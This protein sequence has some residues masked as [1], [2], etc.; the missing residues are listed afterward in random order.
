M[1]AQ[2]F[3]EDTKDTKQESRGTLFLENIGVS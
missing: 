3:L 2:E 1:L